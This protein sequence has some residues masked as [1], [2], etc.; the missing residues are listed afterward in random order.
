MGEDVLSGKLRLLMNPKFDGIIQ[1]KVCLYWIS[2][3]SVSFSV[4]K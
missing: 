3:Q 4:S 2:S 1:M